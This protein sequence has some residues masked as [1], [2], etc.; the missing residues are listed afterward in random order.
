MAR[1]NDISPK[2]IGQVDAPRGQFHDEQQVVRDQATPRPDFHGGEVDRGQDLPMGSDERGPGCLSFPIRSRL[3]SVLLKDVADSG[4]R[5]G[6]ADVREGAL[7]SVKS[8]R[9][10]FFGKAKNQVDDHWADPWPAHVFS[11]FARV[12]FLGD[13]H[14]VPTQDR[15]RGEQRA[16]FLKTFATEDF[17]LDRESAPLVVTEK[18]AFLPKLLFQHLVFGPQVLD[19]L[20]LLTVDPRCE[21]QNEELPWWQKERHGHAVGC[22]GLSQSSF[23]MFLLR[24]GVNEFHRS[25]QRQKRMPGAVVPSRRRLRTAT[26]G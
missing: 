15:I 24:L 19:C 3:N 8:P 2:K 10:V 6:I 12:P 22:R 26:C 5:D 18:N 4:V 23:T 16:D 17:A 9:W 7:D 20:L 11:F 13:E 21:D 14:A 25:S 1:R